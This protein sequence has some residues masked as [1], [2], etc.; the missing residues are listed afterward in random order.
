MNAAAIRFLAE[1]GM[2]L[3]D[4]I[5]IAEALESPQ[6]RTANAQ[7]QARYRERR[8]ISDKQWAELVGQVIERDG[9]ICAYCDCDTGLPENGHAVDHV[10]PLARGG[11]NDLDN[12]TMACRACNS[13]KADKILD[14]E[15]TP[16]NCDFARW[17]R[18][19]PN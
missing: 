17:H 7:R 9:W 18:G 5:E 4:I 8:K 19:E 15:W 14:D 1:K 12:L 16:P 11:T 13:S 6:P 3:E 10:F 2:S